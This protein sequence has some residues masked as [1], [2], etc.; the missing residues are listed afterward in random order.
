MNQNLIDS[1]S[2][3]NVEAE[4]TELNNGKKI[5]IYS[6]GELLDTTT[7]YDDGLIVYTDKNGNITE[8]NINDYVKEPVEGTSV[9]DQRVS[10]SPDNSDSIGTLATQYDFLYGVEYSSAWDMTGRLYGERTLTYSPRRTFEFSAGTAL[11]TVI[12][13]LTGVAVGGVLSVPVLATALGVGVIGSGSGAVIDYA[14]GGTTFS[15]TERYDYE[16]IANNEVGLRTYTEDVT[17]SVPN[18]HNA[19]TTMVPYLSSGDTRSRTDMIHAGIYN[20]Y[21]NNN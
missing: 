11:G 19:E 16:V 17:I 6:D 1:E 12:G 14:I 5:S 3:N 7:V 18:S 2:L 21:L 20:V 8:S 10:N 4:I 9:L 13:A 15:R